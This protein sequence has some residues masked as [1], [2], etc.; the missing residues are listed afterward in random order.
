MRIRDVEVW[1]EAIPLRFSFKHALAERRQSGSLLVRV[2]LDDG[3]CGWGEGLPRAYVTGETVAG[4]ITALGERIVPQLAARDLTHASNLQAAILALHDDPATGADLCAICAIELALLDALARR[5]DQSIYNYLGRAPRVSRVIYSMVIGGGGEKVGRWLA[6]ISRLF[7]I[8]E[9]KLKVDTSLDRNE[10]LIE[11]V[12]RA[13]PRVR[14]RVDANCAWTLDDARQNLAMLRRHGIVACEQ[15]LAKDDVAGHAQLTAENP[16]IL[17]V[18]DES[19]CS[20]G[21]ARLLAEARAFSGFNIRLSKNGGLANALRIHALAREAGVVCQLGAQVGETALISQAGR[22]F[23]GMTGDLVFHEGSFGTL[24]IKQD[25]TR[26]RVGFGL[27]G[28]AST[29]SRGAGLG[30]T[31]LI[32]RVARHATDHTVLRPADSPAEPAR[33]SDN[34]PHAALPALASTNRA[35]R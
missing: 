13:H 6:R 32:D 3:T 35:Q 14:L 31:P 19:L 9:V 27:G 21:D 34:A 4:C 11:A 18:A 23:A 12:R 33:V 20:F 17:I 28:R 1:S 7:G 30:L 26:E 5:Q 15:P 10:R 16:D 29:R 24:L 25:A 8:S 22:L 2:T